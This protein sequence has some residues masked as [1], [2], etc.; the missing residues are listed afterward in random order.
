M[1][2]QG[3]NAVDAAVC[4][5]STIA[6]VA[7]HVT[8]V[9]GDL[10]A[11][12]WIP[13]ADAPVGLNASG[14]SGSRATIAAIK[15]LG[16]DAM[17]V[18]GPLT[19]TVPGA[20]S[21]WAAL[22]QRYGT[23]RLYDVLEPAI[24][25]AEGGAP[26]TDRIAAAIVNSLD[27]IRSDPRMA[28]VFT[29][30]GEPRVAGDVFVNADLAASLREIAATDGEGM[31]RG[32]LA[33][34]LCDAIQNAGGL[35]QGD[36]FERHQPEWVQPLSAPFAG[37][38]IYELPPNT[39]G[40][41][42]LEL[43]NMAAELS[44]TDLD[45][46]SAQYVHRL[47]RYAQLAYEDRN[48]YVTDPGFADIPI[49]MLISREYALERLGQAPEVTPSTDGDTVYLCAVDSSGLAV[50]LIQSQYM[51][52]GSGLMAEGTGI[53]LHN[54]GAFFSLDPKHVNRIEPGKR[55]LHT[56]IPAMAALDGRPELV[57]GTMGGDAQPQ[58]QLQILLN[59]LL[60]G[61]D[62]QEAIES[63]RFIYSPT[64]ASP[65]RV[66]VEGRFDSAT[67]WQFR[68]L[69][70]DAVVIEDWSSLM[71]HAQ[72]IRIDHQKGLLIG[73]ADPRGD[74]QAIGY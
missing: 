55:T 6:V 42:A 30:E 50:S 45:H 59:H 74:G 9:G 15:S 26:I 7:P 33:T 68:E 72:A 10:F 12:I 70:L 20:V 65:G 34:K 35:L 36:D 5:A 31:Y 64:E 63:P 56:L 13:G 22:L 73:A 53:H 11:Q 2:R 48:R 16:Y 61:M 28:S 51:G 24:E 44:L 57:F 21:G 54:R 19:I 69:G 32:G 60:W 25:Y 39:Q 43:I 47:V 37:R 23:T 66:L 58:I 29:R 14:R 71:G 46:N 3:G 18:R 27:T 49:E 41:T 8:G 40:V 62:V 38:S 52:F 67:D 1:L 4:A 17:P